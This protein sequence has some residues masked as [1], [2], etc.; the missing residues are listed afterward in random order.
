MGT[1]TNPV[2]IKGPYAKVGYN[3]GRGLALTAQGQWYEGTGKAVNDGGLSSE[4]EINNYRAGLKFGLTSASNVDLGVDYT[5]YKI[6]LGINAGEKPREIFYNIGY[7]Y[8]FSPNSSFKLLYQIADFDDKGTGF[9]PSGA[10]KGGVAAA[11][12][13]VKF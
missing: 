5:E 2:D 8:S 6:G 3:L 7:G 10:G 11:Q 4:D 12:F 13:Q 9:D 1:L